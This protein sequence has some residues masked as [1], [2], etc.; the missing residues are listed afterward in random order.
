VTLTPVGD[1]LKTA[2][3]VYDPTGKVAGNKGGGPQASPG[4]EIS[5]I[6][7][8]GTYLI[9]VA[10]HY[11]A[12]RDN[13]DYSLYSPQ[14]R[15]PD[16]N[17][18]VGLY[19]LGVGCRYADGT[20]VNPGDTLVEYTAPSVVPT[21]SSAIAAT[22]VVVATPVTCPDSPEPRLSVGMK[23]R[24]TP[25]DAN[26]IRTEPGGTVVVGQIP[27]GEEFDVFGGPACSPKGLTFW[28]VG[29]GELTGW[30]AEGQGTE[31]WLEPVES[32]RG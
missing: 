4:I 9:V 8:G 23:G 3:A 30:T 26:N 22:P 24:V 10:N 19:V 14:D 7:R 15:S 17:G 1:Y 27:A 29:Y 28:Q 20:T 2:M 11:L 18:G 13:S 32:G 21:A 16:Y 31:Y 12:V 5:P 25:G 6:S